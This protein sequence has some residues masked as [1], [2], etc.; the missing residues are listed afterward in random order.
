ME[1]QLYNKLGQGVGKYDDQKKAYTSI[2]DSKK[3][4][5]FIK[6]NWFDGKR[7]ELPIAIDERIL[8][9]LIQYGCMVIQIL[10][11]GV[12]ER[13]YLVSFK[14]EWIRENGVKISYDKYNRQGKNITHFGNQIVFDAS[15]GVVGGASQKTLTNPKLQI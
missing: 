11:L 1:H 13:S 7:L 15:K 4:E 8:I 14:P 3:G 6:K 9:E 10:I 5:I 2:R 12:K